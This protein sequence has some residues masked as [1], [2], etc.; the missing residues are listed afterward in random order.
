MKSIR[1]LSGLVAY[2]L[3]ASANLFA[4]FL[5]APPWPITSDFGPRIHPTRKDYDWHGGID[6]GGRDGDD[7]TA[8]EAGTI[9]DVKGWGTVFWITVSAG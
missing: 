3:I 8:V 6:Y 9:K 4:Q 1:T 5:P 7:I 2:A